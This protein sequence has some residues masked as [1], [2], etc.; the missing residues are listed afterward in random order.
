MA[1]KAEIITNSA[2]LELGLG[3]SLAKNKFSPDHKFPHHGQQSLHGCWLTYTDITINV[4]VNVC[5]G[6]LELIF[7]DE[8]AGVF[9]STIRA[10]I[11]YSNSK[12][13]Q[14]NLIYYD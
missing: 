7:K 14:T 10:K 9:G 12:I 2:Q 11:Q 13:T 5:L 3:L 4:Q 8:S 6:S 1:G